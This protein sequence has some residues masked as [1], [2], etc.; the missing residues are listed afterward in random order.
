MA[1]HEDI[2]KT[3]KALERREIKGWLA[4]SPLQAQKIV[5]RLISRDAIVGIGD[6]STLRQVGIVEAIKK[7]G[8]HIINP[9]DLDKPVVD[10]KTNFE[11]LFYPSLQASVCDVFVT[12]TNVLTEDGRLVNIDG[13]GNRVAG[14]FWGHPVSIIVVGRNKIV[15]NLEAAL[16]RVKNVVAPEHLKRK[17]MNTPCVKSGR[18][19]DCNGPKRV[20]AVTTIIEHKPVLTAINVVIV[21][22]DLGLSWDRSWP[23]DR[24]ENIINL[25]EKHMW[26]CPIN[27]LAVE[28]VDTKTLWKM[29]RARGISW[30]SKR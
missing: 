14:M 28:N 10:G 15:K 16:D 5:A 4:E 9:F 8:N 13:A 12:G 21:D 26:G 23:K 25:H 1:A 19:H 30:P 22:M 20:C 3:I 11:N 18:C 27:R 17:A 29:A 6:S 2:K 24:I 7:K